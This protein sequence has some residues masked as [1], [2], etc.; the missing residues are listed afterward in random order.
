[1]EEAFG[2]VADV[3]DAG[4][5]VE[6]GRKD[7]LVLPGRSASA[8]ERSAALREELAEIVE[9]RPK[10]VDERDR[11]EAAVSVVHG[12]SSDVSPTFG[13]VLLHERR[14]L[15]GGFVG[16]ADSPEAERRIVDL[17]EGVSGVVVSSPT[18]S[19]RA[20]IGRLLGELGLGRGKLTM[21]EVDVSGFR[22]ARDL[23]AGSFWTDFSPDA[24][25]TPGAMALLTALRV[26]SIRKGVPKTA[27]QGWYTAEAVRGMASS[28]MGNEEIS[29]LFSV[30]EGLVERW[31][32]PEKESIKPVR[33][34]SESQLSF[35]SDV[36]RDVPSLEARLS[37]GWRSDAAL[38]SDFLARVRPR[39]RSWR[40]ELRL[41]A[42]G[43]VLRS[44]LGAD[45]PL[46][47]ALDEAGVLFDE[48][49]KILDVSVAERRAS[50]EVSIAEAFSGPAPDRRS[51]FG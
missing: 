9:G 19:D 17:F 36:L 22:D 29:R 24:A 35:A 42:A 27:K 10:G 21:T 48:V 46:E 44:A 32:S 4:G 20:A 51:G 14:R 15:G 45:R 38:V 23:L 1:M 30:S 8:R 37:P 43:E 26:R 31:L 13:I 28:G 39:V 6:P 25:R 7:P 49:R 12:P 47:A 5:W 16:K 3:Y 41:A 50:V 34:P 18:L 40:D 2:L 33:P 11:I